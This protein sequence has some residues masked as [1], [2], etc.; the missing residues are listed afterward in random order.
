MI[1]ALFTEIRNDPDGVFGCAALFI[2]LWIGF[3][4]LT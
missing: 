1:R 4:G 2:G 3:A